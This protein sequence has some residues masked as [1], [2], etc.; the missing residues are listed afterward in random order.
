VIASASAAPSAAPSV[1][2]MPGL[3]PLESACT[4]DEECG[5]TYFDV[6]CCTDCM[7]RLG[8]KESAKKVDAFCKEHKPQSCPKTGPCGFVFGSPRCMNGKCLAR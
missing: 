2:P 5:A 1:T 8:T 3:P 6:L 4:K 7:P